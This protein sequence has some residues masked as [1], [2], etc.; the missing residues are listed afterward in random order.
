MRRVILSSALIA[1][2]HALPAVAQT[3][4]GSDLTLRG[5]I[6]EALRTSPQLQASKDA[7]EKA[8][9]RR[10]VAG[11]RYAPRIAPDFST[12]SAPAGL[13]QHGLGVSLSQTLP[14]G[15]ELRGSANSVRMGSGLAEFRDAGYSVGVS[16]PLMRGFGATNRADLESASEGTREAARDAADARQRLVV[17]T[18]QAYFSVVRLQRLAEETE[19]ALRR[20]ET[21]LEMSEARAKVGL[22]TQL[23]VL[24]AG[25]LRAQAQASAFRGRD[26][27]EAA[28]EDL[29][30]L[31]GRPPGA[32]VR[33]GGDVSVDVQALEEGR[34]GAG[35]NGGTVVSA[36]LAERLD[37][38][39]VRARLADARRMA[40]VARWNLLPQVS[41]D[42][43]YTRR[44][45]GGSPS[46]FA[47]LFNGW[48]V[49]L[50]TTYAFDRG[51]VTAAEG[52]AELQVR[53]AERAVTEAEDRVT[54]EVQ[55]AA[56][57]AARA[58]DLVTLAKT[59]VDLAG[60]QRELATYRFERGLADNLDVVD[61][62]N[63]VFQAQSA[64]IGAEIDRAMAA[65][66]VLRASGTLNPERFL[67]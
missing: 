51:S 43:D 67:Q 4:A 12:G 27:L 33:V 24:R 34:A 23:D 22:S 13:A 9:I 45:L 14:T 40:S 30:L 10:R 28:R 11:A 56:R 57:S 6:G 2:I 37:L 8:D 54:V 55:R 3:P 18:A 15:G 53:A 59:S 29:N 31:L 42:V 35:L 39:N 16:Q 66:A 26:A 64:L 60:R 38:Q 20:A 61:A 21:L 48:R 50:S 25:L 17:T 52:L 62:E 63:N 41:L 44:G 47:T 32:P 58:G 7:I 46:P 19:R 65:L 49:G 5:A 1:L 36:A